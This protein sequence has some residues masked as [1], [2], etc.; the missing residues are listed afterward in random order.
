MDLEG[1]LGAR[2]IEM[3]APQDVA[4]VVAIIAGVQDDGRRES[5]GVY[6]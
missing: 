4:R 6:G 3:G 5:G 2:G 1:C